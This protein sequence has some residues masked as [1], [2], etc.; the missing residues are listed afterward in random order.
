MEIKDKMGALT[1]DEGIDTMLWLV[2]AKEGIQ[3]G[4]HYYER[5]VHSF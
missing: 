5:K 4:K 1:L 2:S 3:S